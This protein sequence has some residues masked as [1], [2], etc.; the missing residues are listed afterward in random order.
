MLLT[1]N[2]DALDPIV[3]TIHDLVVELDEFGV[4]SAAKPRSR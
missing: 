2:N 4:E 3:E 1:G